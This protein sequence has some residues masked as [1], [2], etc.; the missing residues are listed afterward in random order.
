MSVILPE[1]CR[2]AST[3]NFSASDISS[4]LLAGQS[5]SPLLR[6]CSRREG[7][8]IG[9][10][11]S[12]LCVTTKFEVMHIFLYTTF[13]SF[14]SSSSSS[15]SSSYYYYYYY[16]YSPS[17]SSFSFSSS[18]SSAFSP[19]FHA[20]CFQFR[21]YSFSSHQL[22]YGQSHMLPLRLYSFSLSSFH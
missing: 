21:F 20:I 6:I 14:C 16:Y 9:E 22:Y 7:T 15:S 13:L 10:L 2:T 18:S 1:R 3:H 17:S 11:S 4:L 19:S 12:F 8:V 5:D